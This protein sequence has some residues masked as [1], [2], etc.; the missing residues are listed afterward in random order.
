MPYHP[1]GSVLLREEIKGLIDRF[2]AKKDAP[3]VER[4][5]ERAAR[6]AEKCNFRSATIGLTEVLKLEEKRKIPAQ[7]RD[8]AIALVEAIMAEKCGCRI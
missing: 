1:P 6:D 5:V 7:L 3:E 4:T 2:V 8:K